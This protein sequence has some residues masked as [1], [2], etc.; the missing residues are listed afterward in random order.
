MDNI[1]RSQYD[2]RGFVVVRGLY[3]EEEAQWYQKHYMEL[4]ESGEHPGDMAGFDTTSDDPLVRYPRMIHMHRW[5][6]A[7][8]DWLLS[9]RVSG[10]IRQLIDSEPLAVQTMLYFKPAGARGQ[11]LHQ[12]NFYLR[13]APGACV[14]V[15]MALDHVDEENGCLQVVPGS[16]KLPLL[17]QEDVD[18]S[19]SFTD[20][21]LTLPEG[22][23][24]VPIILNPGDV[25]F[26]HGMLI[27]GSFPNTSKDRFR[28]A[29]IGH[30][31]S[32]ESEK[33]AD[34]YWPVLN[35][36]GNEVVLGDNPGGGPCGRWVEVDGT[37][38]VEVA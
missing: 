9:D 27:H 20:K 26:F 1:D 31:V 19:K 6:D 37:P 24:T 16:H 12:D 34:Y 28:R 35:M 22:M 14:G 4:R 21:G 32:A 13:A 30:Y 10:V 33:V 29:L 5:D 23:E 2:D 11:A 15:W 3:S 8:R 18:T 38:H 36:Q 17:C 7:S 25:L